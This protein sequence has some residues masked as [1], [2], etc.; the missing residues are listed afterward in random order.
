MSIL[1]SSWKRIPYFRGPSESSN[2]EMGDWEARRG[3]ASRKV[4]RRNRRDIWWLTDLVL[5]FLCWLLL[6]FFVFVRCRMKFKYL[7]LN[8]FELIYTKEGSKVRSRFA[9]KTQNVKNVKGK[10]HE[11]K[12]EQLL[13]KKY[14]RICCIS[15]VITKNVKK[16]MIH[17]KM[18]MV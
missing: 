6:F 2:S 14:E 15:G 17:P 16:G 4:A 9:S 8:V 11:V 12:F 3:N 10:F 5:N 13:A 7:T 1:R 18:V